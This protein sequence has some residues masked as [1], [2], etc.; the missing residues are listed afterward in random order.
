VRD[1]QARQYRDQAFVVDR[2]SNRWVVYYTERG[3]KSLVRN[4]HLVRPGPSS[5]LLAD[6]SQARQSLRLSLIA[7]R[8]SA[9]AQETLQIGLTGS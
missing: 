5:G 2:W 8:H 1:R 6:P 7:A 3:E 4:K 9:T